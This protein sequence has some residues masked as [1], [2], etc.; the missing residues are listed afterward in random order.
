[1]EEQRL[2]VSH[3]GALSAFTL[4]EAEDS[5]EYNLHCT[6]V[7]WEDLMQ[8]MAAA[9]DQ[10]AFVEVMCEEEQKLNNII[11]EQQAHRTDISLLSQMK[12]Y[13]IARVEE[14]KQELR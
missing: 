13:A 4:S 11:E 6:H 3:Q 2:A 14:Q 1:M 9:D 10:P 12:L 7:Y 8:Q 5:M